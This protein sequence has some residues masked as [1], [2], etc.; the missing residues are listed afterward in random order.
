M[1]R[2]VAKEDKLWNDYFTRIQDVCPWSYALMDKILVWEEPGNCFNTIKSLFNSTKYEAF[3]YVFRDKSPVWL[4]EKTDQLNQLD[5]TNQTDEWLY[6][7][8][9]DDETGDAT[10]VPCLIQQNKAKLESL[11]K[12]VEYYE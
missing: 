9:D 6:S 10:P 2:K 12:K 4:S 5:Q 11:R 7:T 8:P 3:V 1:V